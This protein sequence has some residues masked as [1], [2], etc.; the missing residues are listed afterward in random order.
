ME[1]VV[2]DYGRRINNDESITSSRNKSF[3][4]RVSQGNECCYSEFDVPEKLDELL[5]KGLIP[6]LS[7]SIMNKLNELMTLTTA[8]ITGLSVIKCKDSKE[9]VMQ[10]ICNAPLY[11]CHCSSP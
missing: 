8:N 4:L 9:Q 3:V 1:L 5:K 6:F 7:Q 10:A 11:L 2:T